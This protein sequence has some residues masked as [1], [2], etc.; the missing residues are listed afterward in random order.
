[1]NPPKHQASGPTERRGWAQNRVL[2]IFAVGYQWFYNGAN[3]VAFKI[4]GDAVPPLL[5][6]S[7]RFAL[8]HHLAVRTV[9]PV[10][11]PSQ[12]VGAGEC[13]GVGHDDAGG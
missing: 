1:M 3:F 11:T 10:S 2:V 4:G 13:G 9:A 6:A 12:P 5:L 8:A 7:M